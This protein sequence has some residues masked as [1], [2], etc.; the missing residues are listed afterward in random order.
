MS[1]PNSPEPP[2]GAPKRP[3]GAGS[4]EFGVPI[5][6][7]PM[8]DTAWVIEL[9]ATEQVLALHRALQADRLVGVVD[10]VPAEATL[11]VVFDA[12]L[13]G[14]ATVRAWVS[15]V[16]EAEA[17]ADPDPAPGRA[18]GVDEVDEVVRIPVRYT[19][20]DLEHVARLAGLDP[21]AVVAAHTG[22]FWT[23]AFT[24]FAPG[25]GYLV[26]GDPRLQVPRRESPRTRVP[27]G[28]V[29]LAGQYTGVY[30]RSSPGGWQLI[31]HTT[32]PVWDAAADP[33]ALFRP[34]VRVR[35]EAIP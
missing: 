20:E 1:T 11:L 28:A 18:G 34:G 27:A 14:A 13:V 15:Q 2:S 10:L 23:V 4:G 16:A 5:R 12:G 19:G 17:P 26:G 21:A 7:L 35:F 30:P 6:V 31:G 25:F 9:A 3:E 24:G 8:G 29:G 22:S 33:P 32:T